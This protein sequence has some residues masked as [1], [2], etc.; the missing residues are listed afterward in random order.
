MVNITNLLLLAA[1]LGS[2]VAA[3]DPCRH[4]TCHAEAD[5]KKCDKFE[6][7]DNHRN[8]KTVNGS[9]LK[10]TNKEYCKDGGSYI[11]QSGKQFWYRCCPNP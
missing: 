2:A 4:I 5:S 10:C 8:F 7:C 11:N 9:P 1:T 3:Q 6:K